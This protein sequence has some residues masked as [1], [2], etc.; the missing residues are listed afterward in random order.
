MDIYQLARVTGLN[1]I[2]EQKHE[3]FKFKI[4]DT[5]LFELS[6]RTV[7]LKFYGN[8]VLKRHVFFRP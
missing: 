4:G 3:T 1:R 6:A 7:E 2:P 5:R 8:S